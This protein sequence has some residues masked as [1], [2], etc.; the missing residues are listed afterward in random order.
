LAG[1]GQLDCVVLER[2]V[3][4]FFERTYEQDWEG[5]KPL[6]SLPNLDWTDPDLRFV[7]LT[8]DGHADILITEHEALVWHPA[9]EEEGFGEAIRISKPHDEEKGPAVAF[10]DPTQAIFLADLSGDGLTDIVRIRNGEI[11]YWPNLGY[12]RFG[13]KV[14]MDNSPWFD[15][16]DQFDQER[17]RLADIDGSGTI[18]VIYLHRDG[19]NIYRNRCGNGWSDVEQLSTFPA[20]NN[21]T[22]VQAVDLLGNGTACLVW[23]SPLPGDSSRP[24]RY[25]DLMGGQKPHLL[26]KTVNNLG[27]ETVVQY[28]PST[29]FYLQDKLHDKPWITRL[30]FPVHCVERVETYDRISGN[31]FVSRYKYHHGY[32]DGVEREFRG[33]GMVEQTDTEEIGNIAADETSSEATNL[34]AASLVPPIRT[35]TW[36]HTGVYDEIDEVSHHFAAEYYGA[37]ETTDPGYATTFDAFV[38]TLLPDT[39]LPPAVTLG[40][41]REAARALKGAMLRQEIYADDAPEGASEEMIKRAKTPYTVTEQNFTIELLQPQGT[42]KHTV[43]F[44]HAREA[45]SYHYERNPDDPRAGHSITLESDK[46]GNVLKSVAIGYGRR[47]SPLVTKADREKQTLT[48]ITY[49]QNDITNPIDDA[50]HPDDYRTPL[51]AEART[52]ELTGYKPANSIGRFQI[53]D[54]VQPDP[55]D[56]DGRE[57][58]PIFDSELNYEEA[59]TTD[60]QRRLIE[61]VRTLYRS[62]DL[63]GLLPFGQLQSLA[64]PGESY[65]LAFTP[66]LLNQI[67]RRPLSVVPPPNSP[68]PEVLLPGNIASLLGSTDP[69]GGGYVN[70]DPDG[71]D[72]WWIPSAQIFFSPT[73]DVTN[74]AGTAAEELL[75][76]RQHFFLPCKF[77]DPFGHS[78]TVDYDTHDLLLGKT[79]DALQNTVTALHD[80]RVLQAKSVTDPN[81]NRS[82]GAFDALGMVVATALK[83]KADQNLGDLLEDFDADPPLGNVQSFTADP[84]A[85]A[86]ALI[87]KATTRILCDLD[88]FWRCGQPPFASVLARETHFLDPGGSQTK[89]QISFSYSDGFGRE[90][91]KKIQAEPGE[92]PQRQGD[93]TLPSG[94]FGPGNLVVDADGKP[95]LTSVPQRW[96]GTGRTVFNNKGKPVRQYEPFFSATHFYEE[97][98]EMTNTGVS[99]VLF[100][101]PIERVVATL[102]PDRTW[103]KVVFD[104]WQQAIYDVNDTV[105]NADDSTDPKLD[106]DV[107]GFFSRMP[108]ADYLPTWYEQRV[109]LTATNPERIAAGNAAVHRQTPTVA[110]FDTLGRTFLSI[111]HNRFEKDDAIIEETYPTRIELDIEG[112]QRAVRDAVVQNGDTLGRIVLRYDYDM[113]GNRIHHASMEAGERWM[114]NDVAG[115]PI[116]A[117]DSRGFTRRMR[118]DELRRPTGLF[119]TEGGADRLAERTVYGESQGAEDN[120]RTRVF[121]V[122]D[123]AG[124]V[125]SEGYDFKG[126]LLQSKRELLSD[127]K[128][129][130]DWHQN[131]APNYGTL[132]TRTTYDA[133]NRPLTITTPDGSVYHRTFNEANLLD[134]VDV[135]LRGAADATPFVTNIAYNA[136]GQRTLIHYANGAE[137][138]YAYDDQTFRLIHLKTTRIPGQ[139]GL[140]SQI[141]KGAAT[142]QDL[143]YT[144][145]PAGNITRIEDAA[146][147]TIFHNGQ[148][149]EPIYDY[150]YDAVYRL[151]EAK[152][153]EHIGQAA[154]DFNPQNRRDYDFAG[155]ADFIAHPNDLHAMRRYTERYEYDAVGNFNVMRHIANGGS[156]TRGYAYEEASLLE[157]PKQSNRL[158]QSTIG[159]NLSFAETYNYTDAQGNDVHGCMTAMTSMQMEWDFKDQLQKADLGGGGITFYVYDAAGQRA[160]K[161]IEMQNGKRKEERIYVGGFE[162]YREFNGGGNTVNLE[163]ETLHVRDDRQRIALVET[164]TAENGISISAPIPVQRYQLGNHLGTACLELDKDGGLISYEEYHP[165]GTTAF[166]VTNSAAEVSL[167]RFRY[168]GKER[169]EETGLYYYGARYYAPWLARWTAADTVLADGTNLY[170]YTRG[171]PVVLNDPSGR[172]SEA[173]ARAA[174]QRE[175]KALRADY[176]KKKSAIEKQRSELLAEAAKLR[177]TVPDLHS[178]LGFGSAALSRADAAERAAEQALGEQHQLEERWSEV[179]MRYHDLEPQ[180]LAGKGLAEPRDKLAEYNA[181]VAALKASPITSIAFAFY[182]ATGATFEQQQKFIAVGSALEAPATVVALGAGA[183]LNRSKP[184]AVSPSPKSPAAAAPAPGA[185]PDEE[186][187][188]CSFRT[189]VVLEGIGRTPSG[190]SDVTGIPQGGA[191]PEDIL[192]GLG[193]TTRGKLTYTYN[194]PA[195]V[196]ATLQSWPAGTNVQIYYHAVNSAGERF[197]HST[198]ALVGKGGAVKYVDFGPFPQTYSGPPV[199]ATDQPPGVGFGFTFFRVEPAER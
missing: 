141:F 136:K 183:Y 18:D 83:G 192:A 123:A 93:V 1:D 96:V 184:Q 75:Q 138:T 166:Q 15:A 179:E 109:T 128:S 187:G 31:R 94:D 59:A 175:Y 106:E 45:L 193:T 95:I 104:A 98:P 147:L 69:D 39:V 27:A 52:F 50:A 146:L 13:T 58:V 38:K 68:P 160:R 64:L 2:P 143:R 82:E 156:W 20:V 171:N 162:I 76:A 6:P 111:V 8:G 149:I 41:E 54:F 86:A 19:V 118:Y 196:H 36:F 178:A 11:C 172:E 170:R 108:D 144:Y 120:H 142:V 161:V 37:P 173:E 60:R 26:I 49:T 87:G 169:D 24:M 163:R 102:H 29:K 105:L 133:L 174:R 159:N 100:Y 129:A 99:P 103:E 9:L 131:P 185:S 148:Q 119:V 180:H 121:Q 154:H 150:T 46:Y 77:T 127:Y 79:E 88:R 167:K 70:L 117:W 66:G 125:T 80:Y 124:V 97:E 47:V 62:N 130:V 89:I 158:S 195:Q 42:N 5:F 17:V 189:S 14:T 78:S 157:P 176:T 25:I 90:I 164:K 63:T 34:D 40:E 116:R 190:A 122:F 55:D 4:G 152:G 91:Q 165:Y 73:V 85:Q 33:F 57:Q 43:F 132:T 12:G 30:P 197:M 135:K 35:K 53:S 101:D 32:F 139:N 177:A 186:C 51:S 71:I 140:A 194:D 112:N 114:L 115:K 72:H 134:K 67:Y 107:K 56:P 151:I 23:T 7:D 16:Q 199:L 145:D 44:T 81:G 21:V 191:Y 92:A 182:A 10:A 28:A 155:I 61:C 48:L 110:H 198:I 113:L 168:T 65:K 22:S 153:R 137:T 188:N 126:N 74:P 3:A 181:A 84:Q